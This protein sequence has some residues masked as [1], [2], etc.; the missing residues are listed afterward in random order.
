[1]YV[2]FYLGTFSSIKEYIPVLFSEQS[3]EFGLNW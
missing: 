2:F 1:M 3:S